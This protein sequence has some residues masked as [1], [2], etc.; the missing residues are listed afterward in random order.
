MPSIADTVPNNAAFVFNTLLVGAVIAV[1]ASRGYDTVARFSN[2]AAPWMVL[3]F[4]ACGV[5]AFKQLDVSGWSELT[6]VWNDSITFTQ[7][8]KSEST[9]GFWSIMFFAWF[10]NA[11][12]HV[13]MVNLPVFRFA[14]S[15]FCPRSHAPGSLHWC[16]P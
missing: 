7:D 1:G 12:M 4:L 9:K 14:R 3:V 10:C 6:A 16:R 15:H 13:G 11:A 8:G 5:I 2:V